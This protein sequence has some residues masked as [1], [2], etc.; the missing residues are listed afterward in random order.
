M[1]M[2]Y[3]T[4][5]L[6]V[7][8]LLASLLGPACGDDE[9]PSGVDTT[10]GESSSSST[11]AGS[12]TISATGMM[13]V[14]ESLDS[15]G[16]SSSST[17]GMADGSFLDSATSG[18]PPPP[19]PQPNGGQCMGPDDCKSG[20]CY[21]IPMLGGVC[22][23]CLT[24]EDCEMGTCSLDP[25]SLYAVCTDGSIGV[26]CSSD[27]GC[28]G[29][30]VCAELVDTGGLFPLNFCSECNADTPCPDGQICSPVYDLGMF[31]GYLGCVEPQSVPNGGG[32]PLDGFM[33]DGEVCQ[34]GFCGVADVLGVVPIGV[35]GECLTDMDC[36]DMQMCTPPVADMMGLVGAVCE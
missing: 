2:H 33:G 7:G 19:M 25:A 27:E 20:F 9:G 31:Q 36:M 6:V 26:M 22:S 5:S 12:N 4:R 8:S 29:E 10:E 34:S 14:G 35:C 13:E 23:E 18:D 16:G 3:G 15:S 17:T 1:V 11:S 21:E 28:M 32:C 30:L 24:D